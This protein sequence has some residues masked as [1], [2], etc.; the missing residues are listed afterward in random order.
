VQPAPG[1]TTSNDGTYKFDDYIAAPTTYTKLL[2]FRHALSKITV[3]LKAGKG[4]PV[5]T[6][7]SDAH[8]EETPEVKLTSN[9]GTP[10]D[11]SAWPFTTGTVDITTGVWSSQGN[12]AAITMSTAASLSATAPTG[13]GYTVTKEALVIPGSEFSADDATILRINADGNIYYVT[14]EKIRAAITSK[15][16]TTGTG[17]SE[18][19][20]TLPG[21]NYVINVIV[22][23]T[24]I[25]VTASVVDWTTVKAEEVA[26]KI[27]ITVDYGWPGTQVNVNKFSFYR[28]LSL[29][30]GY[31]TGESENFFLN[32]YYKRISELTKNDDG[33]WTMNP[34]RYWSHHNQHYHFRLVWPNTTTAK[35]I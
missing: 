32:G 27:N 4:F 31:A 9:E 26:P 11:A 18:K 19:W 23:K 30:N 25:K 15:S 29:N 16:L 14:A 34:K 17:A 5:A 13:E 22:N 12:N 3:N 2:E 35:K 6:G 1:A 21:K 10:V 20:L 8:F 28:S 33:T 7:E 24:E